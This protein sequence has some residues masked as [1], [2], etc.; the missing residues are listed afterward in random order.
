MAIT[1]DTNRGW[2]TEQPPRP[3]IN[4]PNQTVAYSLGP[5]TE[6]DTSEGLDAV[7]WGC[8]I[9]LDGKV[10]TS[11][12]LDGA[13]EE[14]VEKLTLVEPVRSLALEF[15]VD[16]WPMIGYVRKNRSY[17][18]WYRT[19]PGIPQLVDLGTGADN[20]LAV[21]QSQRHPVL[22]QFTEVFMVYTRN[23]NTCCVRRSSDNFATEETLQISQNKPIWVARLARDAERGLQIEVRG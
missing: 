19:T 7:L 9:S 13:W 1:L 2:E 22:L 15:D 18:I 20:F 12:R 10:Y 8:Y 14:W 21:K 3:G 16:G 17:G 5:V 11:R 6:G 23:K 4:E